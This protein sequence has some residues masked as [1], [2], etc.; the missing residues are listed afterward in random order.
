MRTP[1]TIAAEAQAH[2]DQAAAAAV[3]ISQATI[4]DLSIE[5]M[6]SLAAILPADPEPEADPVA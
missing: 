4:T 1:R 3:P 6:T 2:A 5:F